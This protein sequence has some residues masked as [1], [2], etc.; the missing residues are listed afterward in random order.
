RNNSIMYEKERSTCIRF[1]D[2]RLNVKL[3]NEKL[4][5]LLNENRNEVVSE[6]GCSPANVFTFK[7]KKKKISR[8]VQC[9]LIGCHSDIGRFF[10][11]CFKLKSKRHGLGRKAKRKKA[12]AN[13]FDVGPRIEVNRLP[14]TSII[15][16][17][18]SRKVTEEKIND[19]N[20]KENEFKKMSEE[21][22]ERIIY[23]NDYG[24]SA[25]MQNIHDSEKLKNDLKYRKVKI[26]LLE[27]LR[28]RRTL[29]RKNDSP[30]QQNGSRYESQNHKEEIT[31]LSYVNK[32]VNGAARKCEDN[33]Q[34]GKI[35]DREMDSSNGR[36]TIITVDEKSDVNKIK[37]RLDSHIAELNGIIGD[38]SVIFGN[39]KETTKNV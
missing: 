8:G 5:K 38:A 27:K 29:I 11:N 20:I 30:M 13:K 15:I 1:H 23:G 14:N 22:I 18:K 26:N 25:Q 33:S 4:R 34:S 17:D 21:K 31:K 16:S 19:T 10:L 28:L 39:K 12:S 7:I 35:V 9:V 2:T 6:T 32:M 36:K 3:P 37:E 24:L